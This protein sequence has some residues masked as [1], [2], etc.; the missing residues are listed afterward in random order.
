MNGNVDISSAYNGDEIGIHIENHRGSGR[1]RDFMDVD[2]LEEEPCIKCNRRDESLLVCIQ[3]GCP[4]S[5]HENCLSCGVKSDD[6]G[7]IYCPYFWYKCELMR[8]KELR[9]KA[10]ETKKQLACFIDP[11][12]FTGDKKENCRTDKGKELNTSSLHQERNYGYGGCEG[13]MD[14]V[15]VEN[16]I[17]EVEGKLENAGDNAKTADSCDRFKR[18]LEN[19]SELQDK[20]YSREN[21][22]D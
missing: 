6:V 16:L 5:V 20:S 17:V 8:T 13:Q 22:W 2:L 14:D 11:K 9:K 10:M 1:S 3:S 4:I 19:Q 15:Q 7:N 12:S 18:A 21:T